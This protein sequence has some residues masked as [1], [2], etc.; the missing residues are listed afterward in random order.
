MTALYA[1]LFSILLRG[2]A[3]Q[4]VGTYE[5]ALMGAKIGCLWQEMVS[6]NSDFKGDDLGFHL[7]ERIRLRIFFFYSLTSKLWVDDT[8][9]TMI[10]RAPCCL[11]GFYYA[12]ELSCEVDDT[13]WTRRGVCP[14]SST[15]STS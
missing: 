5:H 13:S 1:R 2:K 8:S 12:I 10:S 11:I 7:V 6:K 15:T 9:W 4:G 14:G 3:S